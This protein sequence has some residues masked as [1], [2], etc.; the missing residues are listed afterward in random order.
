MKRGKVFAHI[1]LLI[2]PTEL[3]T[4][5]YRRSC[6]SM[7]T[8]IEPANLRFHQRFLSQHIGPIAQKTRQILGCLSD[9]AILPIKFS[10]NRADLGLRNARHIP[11]SGYSIRSW[12]FLSL[13]F[14]FLAASIPDSQSRSLLI[15]SPLITQP[16][17]CSLLSRSH[18]V[19]QPSI[20]QPFFRSH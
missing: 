10:K 3:E 9:F 4:P 2:I 20:L 13:T 19:L 17:N 8:G 11:R 15:Q 18:L 14:R 6:E 12:A 7:T 1:I 16:S 5:I